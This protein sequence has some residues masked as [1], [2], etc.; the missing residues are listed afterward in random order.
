MRAQEIITFLKHMN[1][2]TWRSV[3]DSNMLH[4]VLVTTAL[5][6]SR[7][8]MAILVQLTEQ[9]H[10]RLQLKYVLRWSEY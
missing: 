6:I 5:F 3:K 1:H 10:Y 4:H 2:K 9:I 7:L 8:G